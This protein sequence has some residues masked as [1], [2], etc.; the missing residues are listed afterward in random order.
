MDPDELPP[1][2]PCP[3]ENNVELHQSENST[4]PTEVKTSLL[5]YTAAL[6]QTRIATDEKQVT[7]LVICHV[8][9]CQPVASQEPPINSPSY[10]NLM[11]RESN[12]V[13]AVMLHRRED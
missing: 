5:Y 10:F 9:Y 6:I 11:N 1:L 3:E 8:S 4:H 2:V 13:V 7:S 12:F